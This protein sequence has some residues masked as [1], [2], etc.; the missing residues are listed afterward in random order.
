MKGKVGGREDGGFELAEA[1]LINRDEPYIEILSYVMKW[2]LR[3]C[4]MAVCMCVDFSQYDFISE[5]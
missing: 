3:T 2:K 4:R 5:N 1:T